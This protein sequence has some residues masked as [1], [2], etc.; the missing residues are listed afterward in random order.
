MNVGKGWKLV[1]S[2]DT[3]RKSNNKQFAWC[4]VCTRLD[5]GLVE[6]M[7][8]MNTPAQTSCRI[9]LIQLHLVVWI[10]YKRLVSPVDECTVFTDCKDLAACNVSI[11]NI[12][13]RCTMSTYRL[14]IVC[15]PSAKYSWSMTGKRNRD[16]AFW[17]FQS[18]YPSSHI[19]RGREYIAIN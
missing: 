17:S 5:F 1:K 14:H 12:L 16:K 8:S 11:D 19:S 7:L 6:I 13:I 10:C 3:T 15:K 4:K 2:K 9:I 18:I